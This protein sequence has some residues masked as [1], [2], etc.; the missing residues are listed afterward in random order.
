MLSKEISRSVLISNTPD[1]EYVKQSPSPT[2]S[3]HETFLLSIYYLYICVI[4]PDSLNLP[5]S[6]SLL[7][8]L[9]DGGHGEVSLKVWWGFRQKICKILLEVEITRERKKLKKGQGETST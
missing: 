6:W 3:V 5:Q 1:F 4:S 7:K 9:L 8:Y 2:P